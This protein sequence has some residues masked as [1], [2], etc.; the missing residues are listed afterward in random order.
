MA[1][2]TVAPSELARSLS[3]PLDRIMALADAGY[4]CKVPC[5]AKYGVGYRIAKSSL[6]KD[7]P[8]RV[9]D[10]ISIALWLLGLDQGRYQPV[11]NFYIEREIMR[12]AKL[13]LIQRTE[14]A[15]KLI[16]RYRDA[17]EIVSAVS[18]IRAGDAAAIEIQIRSEKYK[19]RLALLAGISDRRTARGTV[20]VPAPVHRS[21]S[22]TSVK[23][24]PNGSAAQP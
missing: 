7:L 14:Q 21:R 3:I 23:S 9:I 4:L 8:P 6:P 19:R 10:R 11:F 22:L 2:F 24:P 1:P 15:V 12:I 5:P 17:E 16:R 18:R 13:P 20:Q